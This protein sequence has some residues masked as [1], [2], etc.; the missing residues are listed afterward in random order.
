L[1]RI[2]TKTQ[3]EIGELAFFDVKQQNQNFFTTKYET[4]KLMSDLEKQLHTK[5]R[6]KISPI[7]SDPN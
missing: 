6:I 1:S 3:F 2:K 7:P 4:D 5:Q